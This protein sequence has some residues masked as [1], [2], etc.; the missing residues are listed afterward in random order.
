MRVLVTAAAYHGFQSTAQ[1]INTLCRCGVC[2]V[3]C[4]GVCVCGRERKEKEG[5]SVRENFF[6]FKKKNWNLDKE[7]SK[8][9][10]G[11]VN[12]ELGAKNV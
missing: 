12:R 5:G 2:G 3:W 1:T 9:K 6:F 4:R 8:R 7:F 10:K 11:L